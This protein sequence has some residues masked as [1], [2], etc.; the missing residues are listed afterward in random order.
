MDVVKTKITQL[1]GS[2]EINSQLGVGT[3]IVIKVPLTLAIMPTL[4]IQLAAQTFA[5]PLASVNEIFHM[6][7]AK[8]NVVDGQE[9]VTIRDKAIPLFY[10]NMW[11]VGNYITSDTRA[12]R[13]D[14]HVV[15]VSVG[16]RRVGFVVDQL[17]GQEEVVIKPLGRM[18]QGTAGMAGATITGDGTIALILDVPSMLKHYAGGA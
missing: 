14:G 9:C 17:I 10:L 12:E 6:D 1:N 4:M 11:L 18:L 3:E 13:G 8:T 5:L 7:L 15:I 16:T 2:I